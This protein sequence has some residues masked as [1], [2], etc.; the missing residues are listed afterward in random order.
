MRTN[1]GEESG[2][3]MMNIGG[4]NIIEL[5]IPVKSSTDSD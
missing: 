4:K 2:D 3:L 1:P 5:R